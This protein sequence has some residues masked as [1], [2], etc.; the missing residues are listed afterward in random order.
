MK[1]QKK[2]KAFTLIEVLVA[3]IVI[4]IVATT[5]P[6]MLQTTVNSSKNSATEEVFFQEFSLLQLINTMYFDENN[7]VGDNYYKDLNASGGDSELYI[8]KNASLGAYVGKYNRIGKFELNN[9]ILRSGTNATVSAIAPDTGENNP[10]QYDDVDDF[11]GY[12]D[13]VT[14]AFGTTSLQVIV[15]YIPDDANYSSNN[16]TFDMQKAENNNSATSTNIKL[17]TIHAHVNNI[18]INLS[19]PSMNIGASKFLSLEEIER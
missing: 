11:N 16:I 17:I 5:F 2:F 3:L 19:Y 6:M 1:N 7:T 12:E 18:D 14:T 13:N 4:G 10:S 8:E 9:N 15:K